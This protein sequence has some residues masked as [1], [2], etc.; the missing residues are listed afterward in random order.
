MEA[1]LQREKPKIGSEMRITALVAAALLVSALPEYAVGQAQSG[2]LAPPEH[3]AAIGSPAA[4]SMAM[5]TE[6][7]K[8]LTHPRCVNCHPAG[9]SPRQ[10]DQGRLHQPPVRRGADGHGLPA[11]RCNSCHHNAN[12]DRVPGRPEWRLAPREMG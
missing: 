11:M 1:A 7:R 4:R 2:A 12:F 3:F 8:V 10:G 5:F 6:L 9:D